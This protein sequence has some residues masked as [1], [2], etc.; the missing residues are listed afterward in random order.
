MTT[1]TVR[2]VIANDW[3][4]RP[5]P[6][7]SGTP[8][9]VCFPHAGGDVTAFAGLAAAVAPDLEVWAVRLPGRGGRFAEPMPDRF[10]TVLS[11]VLS[12]IAGSLRPGS[13]FY[14]QSFG[15]L[16]GYEVAR[17]L[18]PVL[19]PEVVVPA[20][21]SAPPAWQGAVAPDDQGAADLLRRCGLDTALPD[22]EVLREMVVATIR[23]D[24]Q[25][26]HGY[27]Y[28]PA[29]TPGFAVHA[30]AGAD[31]PMI[32]LDDVAD[33]AHSTTGPFSASVEPGGHLLAT[34]LSAGPARLLRSLQ[35]RR[36][37]CPSRPST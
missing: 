2:P 30:V 20:C 10:D 28:R 14:G 5:H 33:W 24:V 8:Q 34:P 16:L 15:A 25:V 23:A 37:A 4:Y 31:D 3:L 29:P 19:A 7:P 27:R 21:A 1:V 13:V 35:Q 17:A 18:P 36:R 32:R 11:A 22:D 6:L 9:L 12:G 26:T